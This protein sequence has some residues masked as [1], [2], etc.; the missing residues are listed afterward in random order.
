M[1]EEVYQDAIHMAA[2][3]GRLDLVSTLLAA[4]GLVIVVAGI[5]AF[6]NLRAIAKRVAI[7]EARDTSQEVAERV[8]NE[9][10]Q[11][12]LVNILKE[13]KDFFSSS[14]IASDEADNIAGAQEN[15]G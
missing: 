5:F 13:Y 10:L 2:Q 11:E 1:A 15:G 14:D 8:T 4:I 9:Y 12:E 7:A 3:L 6:I